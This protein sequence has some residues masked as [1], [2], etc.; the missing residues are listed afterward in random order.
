MQ[1]ESHFYGMAY[2]LKSFLDDDDD[3]YDLDFDDLNQ[4]LEDEEMGEEEG[5]KNGVFVYTQLIEI[6]QLEFFNRNFSMAFSN[7]PKFDEK[8]QM[9]V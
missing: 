4:E 8:Y 2:F 5:M 9:F 3:S 1:F 6:F 7:S